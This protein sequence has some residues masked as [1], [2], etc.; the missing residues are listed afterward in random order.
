MHELP[1]D[2]VK[3]SIVI[4][5]FN[6][7]SRLVATLRVVEDWAIHDGGLIEVV[8]VDDGSSD[9]TLQVAREWALEETS[10]S[11]Q[12]VLKV[13]LDPDHRGK[14]SAV[15]RG[16]LR[17]R[18]AV[19]VFMDA[20]LAIP[21]TYVDRIVEEIRRGA[22][23]AIGSRELEGSR[24]RGEPWV[25]HAMGRSFNR[26]VAQL[27]VGGFRDTQCGLKG[28]SADAAEDIFHRVRLYP[29]DADII[30]ESRV[31]AFDVEILAI[32]RRHNRHIV[33]IPVDWSHMPVSKVRPMQ[34]AFLMI[35]DALRVR[36]NLWLRRYG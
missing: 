13:V 26:F 2:V 34:D 6:E 27:A 23:V 16:M 7:E 33:E 28:F 18:G 30:G 15:A 14:G 17:A 24:R 10:Q 12:A 1:G 21:L 32:A 5:A 22:D 9:R 35:F 11:A 4:P 8:V 3:L 19:R 20:D 29:P 31:T 25:R 36:W